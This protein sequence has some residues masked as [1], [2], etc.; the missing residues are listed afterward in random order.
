MRLTEDR[1]TILIWEIGI[2]ILLVLCL[3]LLLL[4][5][6]VTNTITPEPASGNLENQED[7][8]PNSNN[9]QNPSTDPV[10]ESATEESA[11]NPS[12]N[13]YQDPSTEPVEESATED[14]GTVYPQK[15]ATGTG[16]EEDPWANDCIKKAFDFVPAGGTIFL[17]AGYYTLS[18]VVTI[19][20]Q[21][22]IVGEGMNKTIITTADAHGFSADEIDHITIKNL[23][24]DGD[25]QT[26]DVY[27]CAIRLDTC[28][29]SILENVEVKNS[30]RVGIDPIDSNYSYF[31][32]VY[33]HDNYKAGIHPGCSGAVGRNQYNTYDGIYSYDNGSYGFGD[34]D[35]PAGNNTYNN[36]N[37]W[38]NGTIGIAIVN[39]TGSVLSNSSAWGNGGDGM[40]FEALEDFSVNNCSATLN[41]TADK[42]GIR[43]ADSKNVNFTNV[44]VKNNNTGISF[45]DCSDMILTA[46]QSYDDRETPLQRFG[47][48]L[49]NNNT[50]ISL[51]NCKITPN[52]LGEI[53]NPNGA[54]VTVI[55][56]KM[57]AKL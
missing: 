38:D 43:L 40:W 1:R 56:E 10:E 16:T 6:C 36:L 46:C 26:D 52:S 20:K 9:Y 32:N 23:T 14:P 35:D 4:T 2:S 3:T 39:Q 29:Y 34:G 25:A 49:V 21:V 27:Q 48:E 47:I 54:V 50:G 24:I 53:Y 8:N 33:A 57:L 18:D 17:K 15:W 19:S 11:T 30:G 12:S 51:V 42:K 44:I 28:N 45:S 55:T 7:I 41:S 22:N 31:K 37:C 13:N 5:G